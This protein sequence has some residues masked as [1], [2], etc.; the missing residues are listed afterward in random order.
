MHVDKIDKLQMQI[1]SNSN[2]FILISLIIPKFKL[3]FTCTLAN[4]SVG[5]SYSFKV[6]FL[7]NKCYIQFFSEGNININAFPFAFSPLQVRPTLCIYSLVS[8]GGSYYII[9]STD[10]ISNPLAATSVHNKT[11]FKFRKKSY[12]FKLIFLYS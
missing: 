5:N 10:G 12:D 6:T 8:S 1:Y 2:S 7:C 4:L 3:L 9:Q 11:P